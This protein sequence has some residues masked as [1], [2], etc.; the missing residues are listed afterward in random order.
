MNF[1]CDTPL[2]RYMEVKKKIQLVL[3][4]RI[5]LVCCDYCWSLSRMLIRAYDSPN[6][7]KMWGPRS[8]TTSNEVIIFSTYML[9]F[10]VKDEAAAPTSYFAGSNR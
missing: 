2:K 3:S 10:F 4:V 6:S 5:W 9:Y 7:Y 8:L 1:K